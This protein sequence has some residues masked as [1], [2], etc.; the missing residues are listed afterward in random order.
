VKYLE[1]SF[2]PALICKLPIEPKCKCRKP[3]WLNLKN[4]S[5]NGLVAKYGGVVDSHATS[6]PA[7]SD[8]KRGK[9]GLKLRVSL[10]LSSEFKQK[11]YIC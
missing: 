2:K 4:C 8:V 6:N 7:I 1:N 3:Q 10:S 11:T 9:N 5:H